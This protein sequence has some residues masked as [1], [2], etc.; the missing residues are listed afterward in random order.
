MLYLLSAGCGQNETGP[1]KKQEILN[2]ITANDLSKVRLLLPKQGTPDF[3]AASYNAFLDSAAEKFAEV[4]G[5]PAALQRQLLINELSRHL[6]HIVGRPVVLTGSV[7]VNLVAN[8]NGNFTAAMTLKSNDG[9]SYQLRIS[10]SET[11]YKNTQL[12]EQTFD[13]DF[14]ATYK[15]T[16]VIVDE[17]LEAEEVELVTGGNSGHGIV[18]PVNFCLPSTENIGLAHSK[19]DQRTLVSILSEAAQNGDLGTIKAL[20]KRDPRLVVS[21]DEAGRTPLFWSVFYGHKDAVAFLLTNGADVNARDAHGR[22]PL[23]AAVKQ[24]VAELLRQHGGHE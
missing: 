15:I 12:A 21:K 3:D 1:Q 20:L 7:A 5:T 2:A 11:E 16:G 10:K 18:I 14:D 6:R 17:F 4:A 13:V 9:V 23:S 19:E 24:D 22:T 8:G